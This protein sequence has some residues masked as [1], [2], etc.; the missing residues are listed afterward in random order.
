M[1]VGLDRGEIVDA[2]DLDVIAP[3]FGNGAQ[4]FN[5]VTGRWEL[6]SFEFD[7]TELV[8]IGRNIGAKK[9]ALVRTLKKCEV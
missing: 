9:E 6:E 5:F 8:F 4:L 2:D 7:R 3:R 1:G